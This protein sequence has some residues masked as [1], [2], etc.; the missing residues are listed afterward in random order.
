MST[1][2]IIINNVKAFFLMY[3]KIITNRTFARSFLNCQ[4][5]MLK[6]G[7]MSYV[8][9]F[10][11]KDLFT[12]K[13]GKEMCEYMKNTLEMNSVIVPAIMQGGK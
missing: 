8:S 7:L 4:K 3:F 13:V 2:Q 12:K 11:K 10:L 1:S 6:V 9:L 5:A